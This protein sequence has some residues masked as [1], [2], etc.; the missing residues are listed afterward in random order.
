MR[1]SVASPSAYTTF[2]EN[3]SGEQR[4]LEAAFCL[5]WGFVP[6]QAQLSAFQRND[7]VNL[8]RQILAA[9]QKL[10]ADP[11]LVHAVDQLGFM[12]TP[13][14]CGQYSETQQRTWQSTIDQ[15]N[16]G[17]EDAASKLS[18]GGGAV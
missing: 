12:L 6:N 4:A 11:A 17:L 18:S 13:M 1:A 16:K 14:N 10:K 7:E 3:Y 8:K 15:Y 5:N 2:R 9:L